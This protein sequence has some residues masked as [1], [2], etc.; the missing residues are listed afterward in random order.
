MPVS[1]WIAAANFS[2]GTELQFEN[3]EI[4]L[5]VGPNNS[6]K[7]TALKNIWSLSEAGRQRDEKVICDIT[8]TKLGTFDE[9]I[10]HLRSHFR[11]PG[12]GEWHFT[13]QGQTMGSEDN[14]TNYWERNDVIHG[15]FFFFVQHL[16][17]QDRLTLA[18]PVPAIRLDQQPP[19]N[20]I[21][22]IA[23]FP[24][25]EQ[26]ISQAF[27]RA[28]GQDLVIHRNAVSHLPLYCGQR[29][30]APPEGSL[31]PEYANIVET[32]M[33]LLEQQ[34]DGMRAFAG[35]LLHAHYGPYSVFM[36]DEP[37]AFLH[38]PQ[39]RYLGQLLARQED[40]PRQVFIATHSGDVL[41]GVLDVPNTNVRVV[42]LRREMRDQADVNVVKELNP[43]DVARIWRDPLLR[44][45]NTLDGLFH[46]RVAVCEADADCRFY[47]A[48]LDAT[49]EQLPETQRPD[50]MFT[51]CGG[52]QRLP[53]ILAALK[54][55]DV[56]V[57]AVAD[58]DVLQNENELRNIVE[59]I[60]EDW[61]NFQTDWR[62]VATAI[63]ER[64]PEHN[65][66]AVRR[67]ID[68][69]FDEHEG[70]TLSRDEAARLRR[71]IS[72]ASAWSDAKSHGVGILDGPNL[73]TCQ[74]L[75]D[76]LQEIGLL[77]VRLGELECFDRE[78]RTANRHGPAWVNAVI[79]ARNLATA[80]E[81][82]DA[83]DFVEL[84]ATD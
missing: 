53:V 2:D 74:R 60:G 44:Y 22:H 8:P 48:L 54:Q 11:L 17:T 49:Y 84:V 40:N 66:E 6:G 4:I 63:N 43:Q 30:A 65:A 19:Q 20:P 3:D 71:A 24:G 52:K 76:R 73:Q 64:R 56:P 34:G 18:N 25:I 57:R 72:Q 7:S 77:V 79:E 50:V 70:E 33:T 35:V 68:Q 67:R 31:S 36:I 83:R 32:E 69:I 62:I 21:Q 12:S 78:H 10:T 23:K 1:V 37:E 45:S 38:P 41:R 75:L 81:L 28:F 39:A 42:R 46:E 15:I 58:F 9:F 13:A 59:A 29:P 5:L 26:R 55:L 61:G 51:H 16:Q 14:L 47:G 80:P 82:Q 27:R